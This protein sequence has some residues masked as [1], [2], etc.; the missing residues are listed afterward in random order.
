MS[1]ATEYLE[2]YR[3]AQ[4]AVFVADKAQKQLTETGPQFTWLAGF[5]GGGKAR[6]AYNGNLFVDGMVPMDKVADF[7]K[8]LGEVYGD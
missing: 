1:K 7:V 4:E 2:Q 8:W 3:V 6:V 5:E